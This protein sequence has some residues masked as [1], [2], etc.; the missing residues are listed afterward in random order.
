MENVRQLLNLMKQNG[1]QISMSAE[2][3]ADKYN[4]KIVY[5]PGKNLSP[6]IKEQTKNESINTIYFVRRTKNVLFNTGANLCWRL[7]K[8][9]GIRIERICSKFTD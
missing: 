9:K 1:T 7:A 2:D 6:H 5:K 8:A 3:I 4:A